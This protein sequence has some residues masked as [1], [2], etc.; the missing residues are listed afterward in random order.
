MKNNQ[1][2][3]RKFDYL[4]RISNQVPSTWTHQNKLIG[5]IL[6]FG[7]LSTIIIRHVKLDIVILMYPILTYITYMLVLLSVAYFI[8]VLINSLFRLYYSILYLPRFLKTIKNGTTDEKW[9]VYMYYTKNIFYI[10]LAI[11]FIFRMTLIGEM[12]NI[13]I[14]SLILGIFITIYLLKYYSNNEWKFNYNVKA[15]SMYGFV[16]ILILGLVW[17][18]V[19]PYNLYKLFES[20]KINN[21]L[22]NFYRETLIMNMDSDRNTYYRTGNTS[23]KDTS[24]YLNINNNDRPGVVSSV[25]ESSVSRS[26][27]QTNSADKT[28]YTSTR[29]VSTQPNN[30]HSIAT[31]VLNEK[32]ND[33]V[34]IHTLQVDENTGKMIRRDASHL[35]NVINTT[36]DDNIPYVFTIH[37]CFGTH[38]NYMNNLSNIVKKE[39]VVLYSQNDFLML[40]HER[41]LQSI[42]DSQYEI[43]IE[44][45]I[46]VVRN[47]KDL[48]VIP[49]LPN[50]GNLDINKILD[51]KYMIT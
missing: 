10:S 6:L 15:Y 27:A 30:A 16:T 47:G 42:L 24:A 50:L 13:Y 19:L 34:S 9:I 23:G 20:E 46:S 44:S 3:L 38:P 2:F 11:L 35:T 7:I 32:T 4:L 5:I 41:I 51:S 33:D 25:T 28:T 31:A 21:I 14:L 45:N 22:T 1:I 36:I 48:L 8:Y 40:F 29:A 43:D 18:L 26:E 37:D 12:S 17:Y 39:F 49:K